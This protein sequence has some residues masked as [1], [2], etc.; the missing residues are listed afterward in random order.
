V[1]AYRQAK[2]LLASSPA[3]EQREQRLIEARRLFERS[4]GYDPTNALARYELATVMRKLGANREAAEQFT[5]VR[6]QCAGNEYGMPAFSRNVEYNRAMALCKVDDRACNTEAVQ[7]FRRLTRELDT[8]ELDPAAKLSRRFVYRSSLAAALLVRLERMR[9]QQADAA[10]AAQSDRLLAEITAIRDEIRTARVPDDP[11]AR[12]S[13]NQSLAVAENAVGRA[14]YLLGRDGAIDA[15]AA[16]LQLVPSFGQ[17]H[18]NMA[19]ALFRDIARYPD[20]E[21]RI[22]GHLDRALEASPNDARALYW[23]GELYWKLLQH[24]DAAAAWTKAAAAGSDQALLRLAEASWRIGTDDARLKAIALAMQS[25]VHAP[26]YDKRA[27]QLILWTATMED[28]VDAETLGYARDVGMALREHL[29]ACGKTLP[30]DVTRS[31]DLIVAKLGHQPA[32]GD[33]AD[34]ERTR[35]S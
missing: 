30:D 8:I 28:K 7:I 25:Q 21:T 19:S 23:R 17:A 32:N 16:A 3:P 4:I 18:V 31:L 29:R 12:S 20:W 27:R 33:T 2:M 1:S 13:H 9:D 26:A 5:M 14:R 22:G 10:M 6:D 11:R 15:L 35:S 34:V 24:D